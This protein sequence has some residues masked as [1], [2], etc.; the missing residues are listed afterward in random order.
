MEGKRAPAMLAPM[1]KAPPDIEYRRHISIGGENDSSAT[2][3][4]K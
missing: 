4:P 3:I 1:S 2:R